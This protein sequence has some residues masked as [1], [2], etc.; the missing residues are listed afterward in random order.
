MPFN[1]SMAYKACFSDAMSKT[2]HQK[3]NM[4]EGLC[5]FSCVKIQSC[6]TFIIISSMSSEQ[7]MLQY[8]ATMTVSGQLPSAPWDKCIYSLTW[9]TLLSLHLFEMTL[10]LPSFSP[11]LSGPD[12]VCDCSAIFDPCVYYLLY[13]YVYKHMCSVN[14]CHFL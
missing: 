2:W 5:F 6:Q 7:Q 4:S 11:C 1:W 12:V 9:I 8:S 13:L 14:K 10:Q 3:N